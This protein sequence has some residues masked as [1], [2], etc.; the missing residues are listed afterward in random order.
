MNCLMLYKEEFHPKVKSD[1]KKIDKS[2][3]AKREN[4]YKNI[5]LKV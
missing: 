5:Q 1:L 3:L 2:V 4:F